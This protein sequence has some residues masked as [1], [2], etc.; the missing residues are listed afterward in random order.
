M[1][2]IKVG[3]NGF[4]RIGRLIA[5]IMASRERFEIVAINDI[6][7]TSSPE[8]YEEGVRM[9]AHLFEWDSVHGRFNGTVYADGTNIVINGHPV[10]VVSSKNPAEIPWGT[11]LDFVVE[12]TGVFRK[13]AQIEQH[14]KTGL[15]DR[16]LLSVPPKD[17]IDAVVVK[18]VNDHILKKEHRIISNASCTTNCLAPLVYVLH[19]KFGV[20]HGLMTTVHAYTMDQRLL[21]AI[22]K[23]DMRRARAAAANIIPTTT[24]AARTIGK[25]I[26]EL[27]GKLDGMSI[28][29]P[30]TD[31]S[32]VDLTVKLKKLSGKADHIVKTVNEAM[33][34][35]A[36]TYLKG[37][38]EYSELP[39]VS[40]DI[41]GNPHS[42]IFDSLST[43][44]IDESGTVK[45]LSWYDN[46]FGYSNRCVDIIEH[47][48]DL[49]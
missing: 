45:V 11:E 47:M 19:K 3:I 16:V 7:D 30:V 9:L 6:L 36:Q 35:A 24:G 42:S 13:K 20:E 17:K 44:A 23:S 28:R 25:I 41:V 31:G 1:R 40:S 39:L 12:S 21:D 10:K 43:M 4:G 22:H 38:L 18:G 37:I 2:K 34:E 49:G 29:V 5:R 26:P 8:K 14:F 48:V 46:E 27:N 33:K 15:V 32:L